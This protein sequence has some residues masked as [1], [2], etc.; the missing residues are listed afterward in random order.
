[1]FEP[2]LADGTLARPHFM[3]SR[4]DGVNSSSISCLDI[5][6]NSDFSQELAHVRSSMPCCFFIRSRNALTGRGNI[7]PH[8][9]QWGSHV[10]QTLHYLDRK[11]NPAIDELPFC[12]RKSCFQTSIYDIGNWLDKTGQHSHKGHANVL[13]QRSNQFPHSRDTQNNTCNY[14]LN[15]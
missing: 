5:I 4:R 2:R 3:I 12:L 10:R 9:R 7:E 11:D 6:I 1:M 14:L 15:E 13:I 8:E